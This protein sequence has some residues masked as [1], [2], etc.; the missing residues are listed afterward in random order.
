MR[1][2]PAILGVAALP[3]SSLMA[4]DATEAFEIDA[5]AG[6]GG[7]VA[8]ARRKPGGSST[9]PTREVSGAVEL[10]AILNCP[11]L[12]VLC[13]RLGCWGAGAQNHVFHKV[14]GPSERAQGRKAM[15]FTMFWAFGKG[16]GA[17]RHV[18]YIT[19]GFRKG[20]WGA[21]PSNLQ[22]FLASRQISNL[23]RRKPGNGRRKQS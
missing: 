9:S 22:G 15:Y 18:I 6:F 17:Q 12:P 1:H 3:R 21:K 10:R 5:A 23:P 2:P 20:R 14:L 8:E 4:F 19:F 11:S 7:S 16:A 13:C